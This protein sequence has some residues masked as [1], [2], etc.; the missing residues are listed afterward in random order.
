LSEQISS[1]GPE[2]TQN[3]SQVISTPALYLGAPVFD[4]WPRGWLF[5]QIFCGILQYFQVNGWD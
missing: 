4:S 3:C 1:Y 2:E 5:W